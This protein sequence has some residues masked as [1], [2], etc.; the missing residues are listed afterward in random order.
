MSDEWVQCLKIGG[1]VHLC[2]FNK[3]IISSS[4]LGFKPSNSP[5]PVSL[6]P[7]VSAS[8]NPTCV[9]RNSDTNHRTLVAALGKGTRCHHFPHSLLSYFHQPKVF[10]GCILEDFSLHP[11]HRFHLSGAQGHGVILT[12]PELRGAPSLGLCLTLPTWEF[13]N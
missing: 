13:F 8:C 2:S 11:D 7:A 5:P 12:L 3:C 4:Y 1:C 6:N 9:F 10:S